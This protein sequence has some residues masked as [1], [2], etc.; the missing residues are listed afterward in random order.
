MLIKA[1]LNGSRAREEHPAL[2][3]TPEQCA[4]AAEEAIAAGAGALH[5]HPRRSDGAQTLDAE[6]QAATILAIRQRYP[7]IAIGVSTALWIESDPAKRLA[8]V[9]RW[10]TLPDFASVNFDEPDAAAMSEALLSRGIGVE[11]GLSS[12]DDVAALVASGVASRALR[13]LIEPGDDGDPEDVAYATIHAL[14]AAQITAPR[15]LHGTGSA[16]WPILRLALAK[17]YD[18][19]IGFEDTLRMPSGELAVSNAQLVAE[20]VALSHKAGRWG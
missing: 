13:V 4:D 8:H 6:A 10:T 15:L 16:T 9:Q 11:A 18:T 12:A 7:D 17:G 3:I 2:P 19:R 14:D 5:I 20:A 1:C